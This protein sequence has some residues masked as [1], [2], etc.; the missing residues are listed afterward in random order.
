[1]P[2]G[3]PLEEVLTFT[4]SLYCAAHLRTFLHGQGHT[5]PMGLPLEEVLTTMPPLH[6]VARVRA[7]RHG[8]DQTTPL[9]EIAT[10]GFASDGQNQTTPTRLQDGHMYY[11]TSHQFFVEGLG[12]PTSLIRTF[13]CLG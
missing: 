7:F 2:M 13:H 1:M 11:S 4:S 6:Y 12:K 8:S 9:E 10:F 5:M 3:L